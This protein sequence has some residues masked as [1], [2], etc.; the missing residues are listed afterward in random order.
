MKHAIPPRNLVLLA[1]LAALLAPLATPQAT[2][3][4]ILGTVTDA[5]GAVVPGVRVKA[6]DTDIGLVRE[7][8]TNELGGYT[9]SNLP[10]GSYRLTANAPAFETFVREGLQLHVQETARIDFTMKLGST[11]AKV[12]VTGAAPLVS[13]DDSTLKH[14]IDNQAATD[15]PL[16]GRNF[17]ALAQMQ[18]GVLPGIPGESLD[19]LLGNGLAIW[20]NGQREFN[21]EWTL[22]G[23]NMNIGFYSWNSFNPSPDAIQEFTLQ[24]GMY[25]A[26]F[27][28]QSGANVNIVIKSGTNQF[29]GVMYEYLQN[30]DMNARNYFAAAIPVLHQNQF[31][32]AIG[33]PLWLPKLYN[34]K[35]KTFFFFN[36]EG[37]RNRTQSLGLLTMPTAAQR[38]GD[39]SH[40]FSGAPYTGAILDPLSKTPFPGGIVPSSR[41]TPQAQKLLAYYP[42]PNTLG[43]ATYNDYVLAAVPNNTD[44]AIARVDQRI[45]NSDT[46]FAH[47]AQNVIFKPSA[48]LVP[49][50]HSTTGVTA[51][52]AAI[53]YNHIFTPRTLN[54]FQVSFN[55]STVTTTDTRDGTN[56]NIEQALGIPGIPA[57]G[58]T[59]GF[60][61]IGILNYTGIGDSTGDPVIQPDEV[62]QFTDNL[63]LERGA[64]HFKLGIDFWHDRSDRFQG[65]NVRGSFTF[66]NNNPAG[67]GNSLGDFLLGLPNQ[68]A[69]GQAPGQEH[70]RNERYGLYFL[71][72]WKVTP[73]LTLNLGLRYELATVLS[74]TRGTVAN[75]NF[76]TGQPIYYRPG[77]GIYSPFY[78]GWAPRFGF[79]YRPFGGDK[80]VIRGGYGIFYNIDLNGLF[81]GVDN[82]PPFAAQ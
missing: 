2:T 61:S 21:N 54:D 3:G 34:G 60:P 13:T 35:D 62:W 32:G 37:Y 23:A 9:I 55:R 30:S 58:K 77:Q 16:N 76:L 10:I 53:N 69:L 5:S 40:T 49:T 38:T 28:F 52:N 1:F 8:V 73:K 39:L 20:A 44:E 7:A 65:V 47:Y 48:E 19:T 26:E 42:L 67:T 63:T 18:P 29:H 75:F 24:T 4:A 71:D 25:S 36:Y 64:H 27:G 82:N 66:V 74:D 81:F 57:S 51:H 68:T 22:D 6:I 70:L 14:L 72:D 45:G 79:A 17:V 41:I 56:F 46:I 59:A 33:G 12:T 31:G 80:T 11:S 43:A 50:F 15:L 78:A